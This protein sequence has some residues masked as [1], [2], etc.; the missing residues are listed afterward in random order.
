MGTQPPFQKGGGAPNFRPMSIVAKRLDGS[1]MEVGLGPVHIV[2]DGDSAPLPK[3]G[4]GPPIFGPSLLWPDGW[5]HQ[6]GTWY[7]GMPQP[8]RLSVRWG[9]SPY[10]KKGGAPPNFQPT[11]IVTK[12]L[13]GSRCYLV[14]RRPRPTRHCVRCGPSYP[15]KVGH[16]HTTQFLSHVYCGQMAGWMKTSLGTEVDL[17]PGH[18]ELDGAPA[19][20]KGAEQFPFFSAHVCCGHGRPSQLLLSA[21]LNFEQTP[22]QL[23]FTEYRLEHGAEC[24]A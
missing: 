13:H 11:Y 1:S 4:A 24:T 8:R 21:C 20:A 22:G 7:G 12:R 15:Q 6:D 18:I 3:N 14:R 23:V 17:G 5:I 9:P 2:L 16:T 19:P 10:P